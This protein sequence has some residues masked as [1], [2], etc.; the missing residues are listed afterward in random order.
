MTD[1]EAG[2]RAW[3]HFL[4]VQAMALRA[5]EERLKAAGQPPMAWCDVLLELERAGGR[6][7]Q[8]E[9]AAALVVE[10]YNVTRLLD[11]MQAAG[12]VQREQATSDRRGTMAVLT[13]AGRAQRQ[14]SW[15]HYR[16]AVVEVFAGALPAA[17]AE[18]LTGTL[19]KLVTHLRGLG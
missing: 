6:L 2:I 4:G 13:E 18:A 14:A 8:G 5:I 1:S 19:K 10:R 11:R 12:L 7:R 16:S 9:L 3:S 17:E 15:P